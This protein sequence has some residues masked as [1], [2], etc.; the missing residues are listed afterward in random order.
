LGAGVQLNRKDITVVVAIDREYLLKLLETY[1]TW[2]YFKPDVCNMPMRI[3]YDAAKLKTTDYMMK[4]LSLCLSKQSDVQFIPWEGDYPSQREKML[5]S[6]VFAPAD[7]VQTPW[8]L[9]I[10]ADTAANASREWIYDEWFEGSPAFVSNPWGYTKP[11]EYISMLDDWGDTVPSLQ[12]RPRLNVPILPNAE[13][14]Y[15]SRIISWLYFGNT[16]WT[17]STVAELRSLSPVQRLPVP[18]QDTTLWY[19][20]ERKGDL[21]R[22]VRMKRY[23]WTHFGRKGISNVSRKVSELLHG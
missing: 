14:A 18:S 7:C 1:K 19:C 8:Y 16:Q 23:G 10:D 4:K 9:K 17:K 20:A 6:L 13:R 22:R 5:T 21:Y 2:V 3:V 12:H 15:H 11:A